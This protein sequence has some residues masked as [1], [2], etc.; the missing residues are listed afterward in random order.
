MGCVSFSQRFF[1]DGNVSQLRM[2]AALLTAA[3]KLRS[4]QR[5]YQN[6]GWVEA[7]GASGTIRTVASIVTAQNWSENGV[8]TNEALDKIIAHMVE[9]GHQ[10]KF[11]LEGLSPERAN[12]LA[13]GVAVLKA[14]F[15]RLKID[16]MIVSDGALREGLLY[17]LQGRIQHDDERDRTVNSLA[18]RY[19]VDEAHAERVSKMATELYEQV[20]AEWQINT[21]EQLHR[22]QW[23]AKLHEV[24]L[25]ISHYQYH[26]HSS[27]LVAH[28]DLPGF[29]REEQQALAA[30]V[31]GQRRSF[32]RKH[33]KQLSDDMQQ[34]TLRLTILLRL[35][36]VFNRGR[37][38]KTDTHVGLSLHRNT[39]ILTLPSGWLE[40]HPLTEADLLQE[41]QELKEIDIRLKI[42]D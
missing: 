9:A 22:L 7:V 11:Q 21:E 17:D 39:L 30:M 13:G 36:L 14:S 2:Q 24:G 19:H 1:N 41:R 18:R 29:S 38:E 15:D 16:R 25:E 4:I 10:D 35:S 8:I 40:E 37:S 26:K 32:P 12:V 5:P 42:R 23:A 28:S 34:A 33:I 20:A 31:R 27:Y 6:L 3:I